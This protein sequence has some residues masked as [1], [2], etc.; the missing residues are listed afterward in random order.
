MEDAPRRNADPDQTSLDQATQRLLHRSR[1]FLASMDAIFVEDLAGRV[2][3]LDARAALFY[4]WRREEFLGEPIERIVPP[5]WRSWMQ[6]LRGRC[7]GGEA[8]R[9]IEGV[10]VTR[11]GKRIPVVLTL[12]L[13][14]NETGTP[15]GIATIAKDVTDLRQ[16]QRAVQSVESRERRSLGVELHDSIGQLVPLARIK[17]AALR[18]DLADSSVSGKLA[19]L[20]DLLARAEDEVRTLT[21]QLSPAVLK[22]LGLAAAAEKLAESLGSGIGLDVTIRN[23]GLPKPLDADCADAV[24]RGLREILMNV[25]RHARTDK[26]QVSL[27]REGERVVVEVED[28]GVGFDPTRWSEG[29]GLRTYRDRL[30]SVGGSLEIDSRPGEG[31][32]VALAVPADDPASSRGAGAQIRHRPR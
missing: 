11:A 28:S 6:S 19:E 9:G 29:F 27:C 3:D 22:D 1:V 12:A 18:E 16:A 32:R 31:T 10:H 7:L 15:V 17:L 13:L 25:V 23:D 30:E 20:D 5:E 2:I 4:G 14:H 8:V 21:F 24:F 26:A